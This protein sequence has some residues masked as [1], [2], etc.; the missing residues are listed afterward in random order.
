[1]ERDRSA[2]TDR[3]FTSAVPLQSRT[4]AERIADRILAAMAVGVLQ[5]GERLPAERDLAD[6]LAVSRTT[7]RLAL[8]RLAALGVTESRRGRNG[9]TFTV[10]WHPSAEAVEAVSRT[11]EP[12]RRELEA[13]FDFRSLVEQLVAR[14]AARRHTAADDRA[15]HAALAQY[16]SARTAAQS[17]E[18][19][20]ALHDAVATAARNPHLTQLAHSLVSQVNLGFTT[21]PYSDDLH[22]T[23]M[24]QHTELV[25][26]ITAG[27]ADL[28]AEL[29]GKHFQMTTGDAWRAAMNGAGARPVQVHP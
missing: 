1:M 9:G 18:A 28:A 29:A 23:A 26:A 24:E 6:V 5:P 15:M 16:R 17:R 3:L 27:E 22:R 20:R 21:E 7:V 8:G 12:I 2:A 19:D 4:T 10:D 13:L 11:L 25:E 14:T